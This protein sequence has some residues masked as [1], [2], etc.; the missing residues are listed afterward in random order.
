MIPT[1]TRTDQLPSYNL[2]SIGLD[3]GTPLQAAI[4]AARA[5]AR[6]RQISDEVKLRINYAGNV[7]GRDYYNVT[8]PTQHVGTLVGVTQLP[9]D[10]IATH[11]LAVVERG[12]FDTRGGGLHMICDNNIPPNGSS[13]AEVHAGMS[14]P[15][16]T[17]AYVVLRR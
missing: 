9:L 15:G 13:I 10:D 2:G 16:R 11:A 12:G 4:F 3:T 14:G 7:A 17:N 1:P 6:E 5:L 8:I